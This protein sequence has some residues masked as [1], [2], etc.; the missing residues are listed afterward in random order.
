VEQAVQVE[1]HPVAL[2]LRTL[3]GSAWLYLSWHPVV[4]HLALS[5]RGPERGALAEAFSF[6]AQLNTLLHGLVLTDVQLPHRWERVVQLSLAQRPAEPPL[7]SLM[8]EVM[9]RYSNL[10]VV[11]GS[12]GVLAAGHQVGSA[13]PLPQLLTELSRCDAGRVGDAD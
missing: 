13:A 8:V 10:V 11:D 3:Q 6:G 9:G 7:I 5:E 2:R 4:G 1:E 12:G